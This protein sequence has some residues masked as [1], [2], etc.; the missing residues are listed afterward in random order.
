MLSNIHMPNSLNTRSLYI[1]KIIM[2]LWIIFCWNYNYLR[3][4][5]AR[6]IPDSLTLS[7]VL[8]N[9]CSDNCSYILYIDSCSHGLRQ[10]KY[11]LKSKLNQ[12]KTLVFNWP[13]FSLQIFYHVKPML[14]LISLLDNWPRY[15]Y[16][17]DIY[18]MNLY[19][20]VNSLITYNPCFILIF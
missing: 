1:S 20:C 5:I 9:W 19:T 14:E 3:M 18:K 13:E 6:S 16:Y 4:Y 10:S 15:R 17:E 12:K 2:L 7:Q 11:N 8:I